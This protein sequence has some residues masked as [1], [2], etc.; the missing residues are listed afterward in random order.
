MID[1]AHLFTALFLLALVV[2]VALQLWLAQRQV[3]HV[4]FHRVAVPAHFAGRIALA[5]HQKAAD[6]TVARTRL[7]AVDILIDTCVLLTLTLGGGLWVA[8]AWTSALPVSPLWQDL[9]L[10]V[11]VTVVT[12]AIG[13]P[14]SWYRTFVVEQ[15]F[16]FNRMTFGLWVKDLF[17]SA[18]LGAALGV[19]LL[20][21]VL[22]LMARAGSWW[23][24][25]AWLA[26]VAFQG[27]LLALYPTVIAPLFN[28]FRP[29]A[30]NTLRERV[31]RLLARCG[32]AAKGL[33]VMDG[34]TRS[35]HGN[36]Y[37]TGF[38]AARRIVF[39]DTLL[40]RLQPEEVEAVLAHELGHFKLKHVLKRTLWFAAGS[41]V[42][43]ALLG[44]LTNEPWFYA[45]LG[46]PGGAPRYGVALVLFMLALPVFAFVAA[47]LAALYSR[48]HEFEADAYAAKNASA[49]A[50]VAALVKLY[51]DN[52]NTLT[53]DPL[54]SA[55]YDSHPPAA[56]RIARLDATSPL[57]EPL[58]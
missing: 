26:W 20:L 45:G 4:S 46:V 50:L 49:S 36:A 35:S 9:L 57:K 28:K 31:E 6:Y 1:P 39:F 12:G 55:F 15:R 48:R 58:R 37:F 19:P 24:F 21:L 17:K 41:L 52:A 56:A 11:G 44:W 2:S 8:A 42:F 34:S 32:F 23:W 40:E 18:L 7:A 33:F 13:L 5:A 43:L 16:G 27:L 3:R 38:G 51:E 25:Y 10:I 53:P 54:H 30:D 47:P 14:L 29:L 22:W